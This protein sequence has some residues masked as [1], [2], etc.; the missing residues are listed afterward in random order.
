MPH[1][2]STLSNVFSAAGKVLEVVLVDGRVEVTLQSS[3]TVRATYAGRYLR[4]LQD[5]SARHEYASVRGSLSSD[6]SL[7]PLVPVIHGWN[8]EKFF[9]PPSRSELDTPPW[10][11][12]IGRVIEKLPKRLF[13]LAV[14]TSFKGKVYESVFTLGVALPVKRLFDA[15]VKVGSRIGAS[16]TLTGE[17]RWPYDGIPRAVA[18]NLL[19]Q[20]RP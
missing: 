15:L 10:G 20:E 18:I 5:K 4:L 12:L 6:A 13:R 7:D 8:P 11:R 19:E 3:V 14:E 9:V 2:T 16:V 17:Y 1:A